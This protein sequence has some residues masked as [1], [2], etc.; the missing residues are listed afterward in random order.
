VARS[1]AETDNPVVVTGDLN[2][3]AWAKA[4]AEGQGVSKDDVPRPGTG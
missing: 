1:I 3:V 4:K 2:D